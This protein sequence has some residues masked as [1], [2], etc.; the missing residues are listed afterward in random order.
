MK[1]KETDIWDIK[2]IIAD[3]TTR[4]PEIIS[5]HLFGSR[6]HN[7]GSRRS[8]I[9]LL[10]Y[11]E[12][13]IQTH[14][15]TDWIIGKY[16][17]VDIFKTTDLKVAESI[18]NASLIQAESLINKL[19]AIPLWQKGSGLN[20][21]FHRWQQLTDKNVE[22][23][24][25]VTGVYIP[26]DP[27]E[28]MQDYVRV[29][30]EK[31]LPTFFLGNDWGTIGY[32]IQSIIT[33]AF[34]KPRIYSKAARS[35]SF[36]TIKLLNEYDF[37][38]FIHLLLRPIF[39]TLEP[40]NVTIKLDGNEKIADFGIGHNRIII[41]AKHIRDISTK[42]TVLK[43]LDGL[44]SFYSM[45]P[46]VNLVLFFILYEKS[47]GLDETILEGYYNKYSQVPPIY[48]CF[49]ENTYS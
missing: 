26:E 16:P 40:E 42:N 48:I 38:N 49:V 10:V 17:P 31:G 39:P 43:T 46:N 34:D 22:F 15:I 45:N 20:A 2:E 21:D 47:V 37:Q 7:T 44:S 1:N 14:L 18:I 30:N 25:T 35:F 6:G 8:D 19:E 3:L 5:I 27:L 32:S 41:E 11:S 24:M 36:D 4:H 9:D 23:Q 12:V 28:I 13:A 33:R 29:L